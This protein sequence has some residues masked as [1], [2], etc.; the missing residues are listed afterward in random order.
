MSSD[1]G[2]DFELL[3]KV[4]LLMNMDPAVIFSLDNWK[5]TFSAYNSLTDA[6]ICPF[7]QFT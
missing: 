2:K 5:C 7:E 1:F 6:A 3:S 4:V